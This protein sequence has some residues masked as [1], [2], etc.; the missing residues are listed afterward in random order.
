V[1]LRAS[2]DADAAKEL[3]TEVFKHQTDLLRIDGVQEMR[4]HLLPVLKDLVVCKVGRGESRVSRMKGWGW[5]RLRG[6]E[7]AARC[8]LWDKM[9]LKGRCMAFVTQIW[10]PVVPLGGRDYTVVPSS[11]KGRTHTIIVSCD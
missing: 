2:P 5:C 8:S 11:P 7:C 4:G 6:G 9:S 3:T 10:G 1:R